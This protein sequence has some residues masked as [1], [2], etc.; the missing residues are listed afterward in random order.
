MA[1][2]AASF[3]TFLII[4]PTSFFLGMLFSLFPYDYPLL[5]AAPATEQAAQAFI[6]YETHMTL[7]HASPPLIQRILHIVIGVGLLGFFTKLY[8]P[9][10]SNMLFDG[11]SLILYVCGIIVYLSN[12]ISGLRTITARAYGGDMDYLEAV[13]QGLEG[14]DKGE[15]VEVSREEGMSVMA[16]SNAIM[17]LILLGVLVLQAG[18]WY[19]DRKQEQEEEKMDEGEKD[20]GREG[21]GGATSSG[22]AKAKGK[23][24]G[25]GLKK[26]A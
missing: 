20:R 3:A 2:G 17:A 11:A 21:N 26:R 15:L 24:G 1:G 7:L 14:Q 5:W 23:N 6:N 9:S 18:Q 25:Q 16:A 8:R 10:E 12:T 13:R 4:C 22:A 19:A